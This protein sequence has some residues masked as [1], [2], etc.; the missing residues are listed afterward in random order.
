MSS[1]TP[2][3]ADSW[4]DRMGWALDRVLNVMF[5]DG[6]DTQTVSV[7]AADA[8]AAGV[9]WGCV[10]C[11]ILG[12]LVQRRHCAITLD[13][14]GKETPGAAARAGVMILAVFAAMWLATYFAVRNLF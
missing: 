5:L 10:V 11:D 8:Q 12:A 1:P 13:P 6:D 14:D 7:H 9:R 2:D 3:A 4:P